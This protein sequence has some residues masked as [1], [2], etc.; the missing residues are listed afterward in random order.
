[1]LRPAKCQR[2]WRTQDAHKG[3]GYAARQNV[4]VLGVR[5]F[6][7]RPGP[8]RLKFVCCQVVAEQWLEYVAVVF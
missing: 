2:A 4:N 8:G 6:P 7:S 3:L 1:M 5:L